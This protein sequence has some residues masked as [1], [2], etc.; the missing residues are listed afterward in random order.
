MLISDLFT[1]FNAF[2]GPSFDDLASPTV[3]SLLI[4]SLQLVSAVVESKS[5]QVIPLF[6]KFLG[7]EADDLSR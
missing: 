1:S 6:L 3:L 5:R 4:K 7:Y 2:V